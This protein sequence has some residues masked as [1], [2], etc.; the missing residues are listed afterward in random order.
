MKCAIWPSAPSSRPKKFTI[1]IS[2][3]QTNTQTVVGVIN[4]SS[5][6]LS[7]ERR[8]GERS[9]RG[10]RTDCPVDAATGRTQRLDRQR[11]H[12]AVNRGRRRQSQR[13]RSGLNWPA[14]PPTAPAK[15]RR[16]VNTSPAWAGRSTNWCAASGSDWP[17]AAK[18]PGPDSRAGLFCDSSRAISASLHFAAYRFMHARLSCQSFAFTASQ[19]GPLARPPWPISPGHPTTRPCG[20]AALAR[21]SGGRQNSSLRSS[22]RLPSLFPVSPALLAR[23][24]GTN[25]SAHPTIR[26]FA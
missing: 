10:T 8:P 14:R 13:H 25:P 15:P 23:V 22:N 2:K 18:K 4:E 9:R 12:P 3:L 6:P 11:N 24:N 7:G 16:P 21:S 17:A 19:R 1:M 5:Q 26:A 20:F